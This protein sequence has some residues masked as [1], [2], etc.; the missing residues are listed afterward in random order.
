MSDH[1]DH[2][3]FYVY[4]M[5]YPLINSV[6]M[7]TKCR[8]GY[9]R[10]YRS[11]TE[12]LRWYDHCVIFMYCMMQKALDLAVTAWHVHIATPSLL[13]SAAN[14]SLFLTS[15]SLGSGKDGNKEGIYL[16]FVWCE[17]D[18]GMPRLVWL[19][20][21]L[22]NNAKTP[23]CASVCTDSSDLN[24]WHAGHWPALWMCGAHPHYRFVS[25]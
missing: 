7:A 6:S 24:H 8:N 12:D 17:S 11:A 18:F 16:Q 14:M 2:V 15:E 3:L 4:V 13:L 25:L 1:D 21:A 23:L 5:F 9:W 10:L 19:N 22:W 20:S